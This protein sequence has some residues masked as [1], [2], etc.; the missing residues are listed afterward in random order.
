[1]TFLDNHDQPRFLSRDRANGNLDRLK[2]ALAFLYTARGIPCLYYGT[3]QGF[4]GGN[5][6][7]DRE[8]MFAGKFEWGPS[9]GD[10]FNLTHPL[11]QW[12]ARLNNFRRLYPAL[13]EGAHVNLWCDP[14]GPGLLA[15]ARRLGGQEIFVALN[16]SGAAQKLAARPTVYLPGTRLVNILDTNESFAVLPGPSTPVLDLPAVSAKIFIA[17]KLVLQ[18]DPVVVS[19][20]PT[21]D[22]RE[23]SPTAPVVI[24]F[25]EPM[26]AE[27]AAAALSTS[28]RVDG[29]CSWSA[30]RET[31]TFTPKATGFPR[32]TMIEARV[33]GAAKSAATGK[34]IQGGFS[35]RFETGGS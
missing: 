7:Y 1:M 32:H 11:F 17:Q 5:D 4:N 14:R 30:S 28:P 9:R 6:P 26:D 16:T 27:S 2:V 3:E 35:S 25:S 29:A 18:L 13:R 12:V 10:N 23:V 19:V 31:L 15:Y 33:A 20:L 8:D 34:H 21:H 24:Q 22:S